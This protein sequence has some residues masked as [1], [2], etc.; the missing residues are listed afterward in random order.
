[1][2][3][4]MYVCMC[5][6]SVFLNLCRPR[7]RTRKSGLREV[8]CMLIFE[9]STGIQYNS[10]YQ[11]VAQN[12]MET[13]RS[14]DVRTYLHVYCTHPICI[15]FVVAFNSVLSNASSGCRVL[16]MQR[17]HPS[18]VYLDGGFNFSLFFCSF[19]ICLFFILSPLGIPRFLSSPRC[20]RSHPC[21]L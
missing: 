9:H 6:L 18:N 13:K 19:F 4:C 1:M 10:C 17:Q 2:H 5:F 3:A 15:F 20:M 7:Q 11:N 21:L 16:T 14:F 8:V 12:K